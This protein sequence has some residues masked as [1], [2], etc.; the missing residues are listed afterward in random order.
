MFVLDIMK[1]IWRGWKRFVHRLM[2]VQ[3]WVLMAG[4][5]WVAV[6]PVA[7]VMRL[8]NPDLTDRGLGDTESET[9]WL[10]PQMGFQDIRRAQR[11]Y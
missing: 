8:G 9:Y 10:E 3:S 4:T 6:G 7:V 1:T 2:A 5:Y 11:P